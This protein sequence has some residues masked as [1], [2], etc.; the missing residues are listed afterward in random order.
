MTRTINAFLIL[1]LAAFAPVAAAQEA[2]DPSGTWKWT[3]NFGGN[4]MERVLTLALD[5]DALSGT[6]SGPN[7][8]VTEIQDATYEDGKVAFRVVR[9]F[10]GQ[11][12]AI[13]YSG[14][15]DGD[16]LKGQTSGTF[17][18]QERSWDWEATRSTD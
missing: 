16:V 14:T 1:M 3:V 12:F 4:T 18:G 5:A 11:E 15:V 6:I 2:P 10:N 9:S 17:G 13:S 7:D 8:S